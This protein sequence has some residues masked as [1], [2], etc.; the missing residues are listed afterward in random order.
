MFSVTLLNIS[1]ELMVSI[2]LFSVWFDPHPFIS[3]LPL[4]YE[5]SNKD[6]NGKKK[7]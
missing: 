4:H 3:Y 6:K 1:K 7:N 2:C 5:L